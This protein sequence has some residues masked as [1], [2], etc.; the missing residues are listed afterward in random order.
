MQRIMNERITPRLTRWV[1]DIS[2]EDDPNAGR[3]IHWRRSSPGDGN[4][5]FV[6]DP[7]T[8]PEPT[9]V[10]DHQASPPIALP[11]ARTDEE[12]KA[13]LEA[14]LVGEEP[15]KVTDSVAMGASGIRTAAEEVDQMDECEE[16]Y[17]I[18]GPDLWHRWDYLMS[19]PESR[20]MLKR[21]GLGRLWRTWTPFLQPEYPEPE[22]RDET[23][24]LPYA[25]DDGRASS[26]K[27]LRERSPVLALE[28]MVAGHRAFPAVRRSPKRKSEEMDPG[29]SMGSGRAGERNIRR[30]T[31]ERLTESEA[32]S[33][34]EDTEEEP[35]ATPPSSPSF[36]FANLPPRLPTSEP[37]QLGEPLRPRTPLPSCRPKTEG[38]DDDGS[39][40][41]SDIDKVPAASPNS[42][43]PRFANLPSRLPSIEEEEMEDDKESE[44]DEERE[45]IYT[46]DLEA[47]QLE[48]GF[49]D[50]FNLNDDA[51]THDYP[52]PPSRPQTGRS[53]RRQ[54]PAPVI[55]DNVQVNRAQRLATLLPNE[56]HV[57]T[58]S[59]IIKGRY[60]RLQHRLPMREESKR[61][62]LLRKWGDDSAGRYKAWH[63]M[64][65]SMQVDLELAEEFAMREMRLTKEAVRE[66]QGSGGLLQGV[67]DSMGWEFGE[68]IEAIETGEKADKA[69][70][71]MEMAEG[72][73]DEA[74]E[75]EGD[76]DAKVEATEVNG[77][78]E[79]AQGG[80]SNGNAG[81]G[82]AEEDEDMEDDDEEDGAPLMR[83]QSYRKDPRGSW[84]QERG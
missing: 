36:L 31:D 67:M 63:E 29:P 65:E 22:S 72:G 57:H 50:L 39:S 28:L 25:T 30:P 74:A 33:V 61:M 77:N 27:M 35:L 55:D 11:T 10:P 6:P 83:V 78:E 40:S 19:I 75:G 15:V 24:V 1:G 62:E 9:A 60:K 21:N 42:P 12:M 80:N 44:S 68:Q 2:I 71:V 18:S 56:L 7:N 23:E 79:E 64:M 70:K 45:N 32:F 59:H 58:M 34:W 26:S 14:C 73:N 54:P 46:M 66:L 17:P 82:G 16:P 81:C 48:D 47:R 52:V 4:F 8:F 20:A 53:I 69:E 3:E 43:M 76:V 51:R 38:G 13:V 37:E 84:W 41:E 5:R 49:G